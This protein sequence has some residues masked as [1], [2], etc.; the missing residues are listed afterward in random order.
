MASFTTERAGKTVEEE[1]TIVYRSAWREN[2]THRPPPGGN[3]EHKRGGTFYRDWEK[4]R[5]HG[6]RKLTV[7]AAKH[8]RSRKKQVGVRPV[9]GRPR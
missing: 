1:M 3:L 2:K 8:I 6:G 5:H 9:W 4:P 7:S